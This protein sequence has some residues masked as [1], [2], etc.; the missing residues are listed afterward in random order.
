MKNEHGLDNRIP[1]LARDWLVCT[2]E[3]VFDSI[4]G[5]KVDSTGNVPTFVLVLK[6]AINNG[7]TRDI[8]RIAAIDEVF[9]LRVKST[10]LS[11]NS[12][13][14]SYRVASYSD[15]AVFTYTVTGENLVFYLLDTESSQASGAAAFGNLPFLE[16]FSVAFA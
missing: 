7:E 2:K 9:E 12:K 8:G 13:P 3:I 5:V 14:T 1:A 6:P 4:C 15:Q 10:S 16:N 11:R